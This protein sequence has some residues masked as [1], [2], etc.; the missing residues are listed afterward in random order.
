MAFNVKTIHSDSR[1]YLINVEVNDQNILLSSNHVA[2]I[3]HYNYEKFFGKIEHD[4]LKIEINEQGS[5]KFIVSTSSETAISLRT[6]ILLPPPSSSNIRN[7]HIISESSFIQP[8][9]HDSRMFFPPL[10]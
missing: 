5:N 8:L 6:A 9:I 1:H 10:I 4:K 7:L 2:Q 3:I